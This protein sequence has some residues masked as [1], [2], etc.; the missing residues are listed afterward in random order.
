MWALNH[1]FYGQNYG[2]PRFLNKSEW[3][4]ESSMIQWPIHK[5]SHLPRFWMNESAESIGLL[6]VVCFHIKV[7]LHFFPTFLI[8]M[9]KNKTLISS[10]YLCIHHIFWCKCIYSTSNLHQQ[11]VVNT[12]NAAFLFLYIGKMEFDDTDL[13]TLQFLII[14]T[15]E[16][17]QCK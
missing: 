2:N 6:L 7:L 12:S 13:W 8:C 16:L 1:Y 11:S 5:D 9:S 10:H 17:K 3:M 14:L 4:N 15:E